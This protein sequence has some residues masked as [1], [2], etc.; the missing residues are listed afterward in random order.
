MPHVHL[1]GSVQLFYEI[2]TVDGRPDPN[3]ASLLLIAP[4]FLDAT[5][6][7]HYVDEF[8]EDYS[9]T[10]LELRS[11]GRSRNPVKED[12]DFWVA[13]ADIAFAMEALQLP[14]SHVFGAGC[15]MFQA[16]LKL[17]LLWP[18]RVLS[19]S[20]VGAPALFAV[21]SNLEAFEEIDAG[22]MNPQDTEHWVEVMGGIGDFCLSRDTYPNWR[23][24]WDWAVPA[25]ARRHNPYRA[26][27]IWMHSTPNHRHPGLTPERLATIKQ[28]ILFIHGDNDTCYPFE[29][30][31]DQTEHFK[32]SEDLRFHVV[33]GGGHLLA[34]SHTP[35]VIAHMRS[36]LSRHSSSPP[37]I[38]SLDAYSALQKAAG[39]AN[40]PSIARRNPRH[41]DSFSLVTAEEL[42]TGRA[43]LERAAKIE[44]EFR[45]P[46]PMCF[47]KDDWEEGAD[48]QRRFTWSTREEY[49]QRIQGPRPL[50]NLSIQGI[51]VEVE[52]EE[53]S[54]RKPVPA[55]ADEEG[56]AA[57]LPPPVPPKA[58]VTV[59][60]R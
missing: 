2:H 42:E 30:V 48:Q 41:P 19:L 38:P 9:V 15:E 8:R 56:T 17:S 51:S 23:E 36:F 7:Q 26:R 24:V 13:S 53:V 57:D 37:S 49:L 5:F 60:R 32:G 10:T 54:A 45:I 20:L 27:N 28:P 22:W 16:A 39:Y 3:K 6:L 40:D 4:T 33:Q 11:Q 35:A 55:S 50:S 21:P 59:G 29:E 44:K 52:E 14:P 12:Y 1:P 47:E 58:Q 43:E 18:N 31:R 34:I 25:F 46:L